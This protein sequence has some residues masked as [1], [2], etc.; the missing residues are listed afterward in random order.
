VAAN[1]FTVVTN[2]PR[3]ARLTGV[4]RTSMQEA[5]GGADFDDEILDD[6]VGPVMAF[7]R[8]VSDPTVTYLALYRN[9]T[10]VYLYVNADLDGAIVTTVKP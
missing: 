2:D 6:E 1:P 10:K 4:A 3:T 7:G 9:G 5:Q 8:G